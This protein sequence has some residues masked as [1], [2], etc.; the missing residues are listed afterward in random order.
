MNPGAIVIVSLVQAIEKYWGVL[1]FLT[2]PGVTLLG[3]NLSSFD[4]WVR[5][6]VN[7]SRPSLG[8]TTVFFPMHRV[9]RI[10]VDEP[11]GE[12]E[13]LRQSFERRVGTPLEAYLGRDDGPAVTH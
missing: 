1:E 4:D 3:I 13:S 6:V 7:E 8:L 10:F 12:V 9:E 11:V 2:Q 5:A